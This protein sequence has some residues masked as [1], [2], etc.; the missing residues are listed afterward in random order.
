MM[1]EFNTNMRQRGDATYSEVLNHIRTGRQTP[2]DIR[3]LR[4]RL[5]SGVENPLCL[6]DERFKG[7]LPGKIQVEEYNDQCLQQ[8]ATTSILEIRFLPAGVSSGSVPE[9][10]I[11]KEDRDCGGLRSTLKLAS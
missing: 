10:L 4:S 1:F 11:P 7:L 9:I 3:L 8:H 2:G 5:M 6:S